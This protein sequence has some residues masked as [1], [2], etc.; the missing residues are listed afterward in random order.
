MAQSA[1]TFGT[2]LETFRR[3]ESSRGVSSISGRW[4]EKAV[5]MI[6]QYLRNEKGSAPLGQVRDRVD[7]SQ[8]DFLGALMAG[9]DKGLFTIDEEPDEPVV[10]LTKLGT[11]LAR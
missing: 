3:L 5:L 8:E 7:L 1:N 2:F 6:A 9:R 4:P 10:K 11:S